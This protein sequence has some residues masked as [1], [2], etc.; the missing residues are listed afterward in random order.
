V[1]LDRFV[2]D[3]GQ[4]W[5]EL[6]GLLARA[7]G[8]PERL[9]PDGVRRLGALYRGAAADLARG[10]RAFG[11]DPVVVRLESLVGRAR[12]VIYDAAPRRTTLRRFVTRDYWRLIAER[13]AFVLAAWALMLIPAALAAVWSY[14]DP[15]AGIGLVPEEFRSSVEPGTGRDLTPADQAAFAS[16]LFTNNITVTFS[17]FAGGVLLGLGAAAILIFNGVTLGAVGGVATQSGNGTAF[18]DLINPHGLLE[19]SCIAVTAAAGMRMGW[20]L[21]E[22][23]TRRRGTALVEEARRAVGIVLGTMP[24][25]VLAGVFESF[26]R[27]AGPGVPLTLP[28]GLVTGTAFWGLVVWRGRAGRGADQSLALDLARK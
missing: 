8:R 14:N 26:L 16:Q 1:N 13:P 22:P 25:L 21:V 12:P 6:D 28:L 2:A 5:E 19:L 7:R 11:R 9:G 23:G 24:W 10:R 20:A 18:V 3:R 15:A 4:A 27:S 17:A